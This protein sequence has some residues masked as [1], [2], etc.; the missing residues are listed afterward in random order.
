MVTSDTMF[1]LAISYEFNDTTL[2]VVTLHIIELLSFTFYFNY[3]QR[4]KG[5]AQ[6]ALGFA[7]W[8]TH[9]FKHVCT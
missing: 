5:Y 6:A 4:D 2:N 3:F 8:P 1:V 7:Q 9:D